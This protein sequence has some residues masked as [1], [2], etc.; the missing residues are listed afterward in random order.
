MILRKY[1]APRQDPKQD[2][3]YRTWLRTL[4]CIVCTAWKFNIKGYAGFIECAHFGSRGLGQKCS[5]REALPLCVWH[6]RTGPKAVHVLGRNFWM[7]WKL[8][9]Y[10]LIAEHNRK[11]ERRE[12]NAA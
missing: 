10:E 8:D 3:D 5:D 12:E 6:H 9:R 7:H 1:R 11:F 2:S 4:P